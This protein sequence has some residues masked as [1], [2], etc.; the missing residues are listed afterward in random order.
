MKWFDI[1][2]GIARFIR[3]R[4]G[5]SMREWSEFAA[6]K[7]L[8]AAE[9]LKLIAGQL[10]ARALARRR[11]RSGR[12]PWLARRQLRAADRLRSHAVDLM[13]RHFGGKCL[14]DPNRQPGT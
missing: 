5:M 2:L 12:M 4:L 10:E 13:A 3:K 9:Q 1:V 7:P 11:R 6:A 14:D 8:A